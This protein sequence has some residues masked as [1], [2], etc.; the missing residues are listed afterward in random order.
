MKKNLIISILSMLCFLFFFVEAAGAQLLSFGNGRCYPINFR[1]VDSKYYRSGEL[2][3]CNYFDLKKL[4]IK[5]VIDLR[6]NFLGYSQKEKSASTEAGINYFNIPMNP[7]FP[8]S[9]NQIDKFFSIIDNSNNLPVLV[10]CLH[11]QDRTGFMTALYRIRND[12]WDYEQAYAEMLSYG[13]HN[14]RYPLLKLALRKYSRELS[15]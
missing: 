10:H 15:K 7:F 9:K 13:Y 6:Q 11:G 4:G 5:T 14:H 12:R 8:P 2:E 1:K 3:K